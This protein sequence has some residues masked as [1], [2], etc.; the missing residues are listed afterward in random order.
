[1][2]RFAM[3]SIGPIECLRTWAKTISARYITSIPCAV[4]LSWLENAYIHSHFFG[5]RFL[6]VKQVR[7]I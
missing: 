1:M 5:G 2:T 7:L 4:R 6:S 3:N